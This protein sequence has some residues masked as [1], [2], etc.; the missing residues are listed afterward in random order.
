MISLSQRNLGNAHGTKFPDGSNIIRRNLPWAALFKC[1][2]LHVIGVRSDPKMIWSNTKRSIA[3]VKDVA[4]ERQWP[5]MQN[6]A[7]D[8]SSDYRRIPSSTAANAPIAFSVS[9]SDPNPAGFGFPNLLPKALRKIGRKSLLCEILSRYV[10][11]VVRFSPFRFAR[12]NGLLYFYQSP[13]NSS[14]VV[15]GGTGS[16]GRPPWVVGWPLRSCRTALSYQL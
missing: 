12:A 13:G 15:V 6:P 3:P 1:L 2:I 9:C 14:S 7:C 16:G 5:E 4:T 8:M 10:D 11:H